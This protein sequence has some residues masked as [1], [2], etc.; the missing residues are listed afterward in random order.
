MAEN[1][2]AN[3]REYARMLTKNEETAARMG[4]HACWEKHRRIFIACVV[5]AV[6]D[7]GA[8]GFPRLFLTVIDDAGFIGFCGRE[9]GEED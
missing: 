2:N 3:G 4:V 9:D 6:C 1:L 7:L 8:Q 5:C